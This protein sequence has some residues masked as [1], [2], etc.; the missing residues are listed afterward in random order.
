MV[1]GYPT[2]VHRPVCVEEIVVYSVHIT[3]MHRPFVWR[4]DTFSPQ[5]PATIVVVFGLLRLRQV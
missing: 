5:I 1:Q 3:R 4:S 2:E